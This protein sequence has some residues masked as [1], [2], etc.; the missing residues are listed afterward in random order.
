MSANT[1]KQLPALPGPA[2]RTLSIIL[3][4][5]FGLFLELLLIRWIG[6]EVRIFAYLQNTVLIVCFLGLGMGCFT[7]HKPARIRNILLPLA[8]FTLLLAIPLTHAILAN[9]TNLLSVLDDLLIW[10]RVASTGLMT[11]VG[12][13]T[14]GLTL[15]LGLMILIWEMFVPI[16]RMLGRLMDD[17]RQI[18]WVYSVNVAASLVGIWLFVGLSAFSLPPVLWLS[19]ACGLLEIGRAHV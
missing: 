1:T 19:I 7:S 8:I 5:I 4:S 14:A 11:T 12:C 17:Q 13:V 10:E 6:T 15:T 9:I 16:G 2:N 3:V 18:I